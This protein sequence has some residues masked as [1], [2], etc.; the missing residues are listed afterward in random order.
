MSAGTAGIE[1]RDG[2]TLHA[3]GVMCCQQ[4]RLRE[5]VRYFR[6]ALEA[7]PALWTAWCDLGSACG[8]LG[9]HGSAVCA[10]DA[11]IALRPEDAGLHNSRGVALTRLKRRTEALASF[12]RAIEL[13]PSCE[14]AWNNRAGVLIELQRHLE[15]V[16]CAGCALS[17]RPDYPQ[18]H[19]NQGSAL[20]AQR[21]YE[22][23]LQCFD[24]AIALAP[25]FAAAWANRATALAG[26]KRLPEAVSSAEHAIAI[27][28]G[29][30]QAHLN[31]GVALADLY[32]HREALECFDWAIA[33]D[34]HSLQGHINRG[35]ALSYLQRHEEAIESFDRALQV[36]TGDAGALHNRALSRLLLGRLEQGWR[37]WEHRWASPDFEPARHSHLSR[38]NGPDSPPARRVLLW[39]EQ[40]LGDTLHFCRYAPMVQAL[41]VEVVLEVQAPLE[42]VLR[43]LQGVSQ[44]VRQGEPPPACDAQI[45]LM[46]LPLA[47]GTD[48]STI[49]A[50]IPYLH[51]DPHRS[52][53]WKQRLGARVAPSVGLVCSG[54]PA[55]RNDRSRSVP[56]R[57]F[58]PLFGAADFYLLQTEVRSSDEADLAAS[59]IRDLR[60][61]LKDFRD[62]AALIGCL[63]LVI[64]VDTAVAHL[65]G[66][67][68]RP[69]WILLPR[70]PDWRWMLDRDDSPWYPTA[71][72]F[73][74]A[75]AGDWSCVISSVVEALKSFRA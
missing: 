39:C 12:E 17:L 70:V 36:D 42:P 54:G 28:P 68:G 46:S 45:P 25:D 2:A 53:L 24:R 64:S 69:V 33:L 1:P 50:S 40:G 56:L 32:R 30:V 6:Q 51:A 61:E 43:T 58:Q 73:R 10:F 26:L 47:L 18:A 21:K 4:G 22:E 48:L 15:A 3:R 20:N 41:G 16:E 55:Y 19:N 65:T 37:D 13:S 63:D 59:G 62:T 38:W 71:S 5:G 35:S 75:R 23:A 11:A 14:R 74:Q 31:R 44:L 57:L 27:A 34:P 60:H 72:L 7:S 49:P 29:S 9:E 67:M 8:E 52:G 66:A